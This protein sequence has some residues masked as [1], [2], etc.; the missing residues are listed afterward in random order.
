MCVCTFACDC[1]DGVNRV[2]YSN[3][4]MMFVS[5]TESLHFVGGKAVTSYVFHKPCLIMC[6]FE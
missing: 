3:W 1:H 2:Q 5:E 6:K 4:P